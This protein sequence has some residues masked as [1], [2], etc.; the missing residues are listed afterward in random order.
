[1]FKKINKIIFLSIILFSSFGYSKENLTKI[2][3]IDEFSLFTQ[4][5]YLHPQP[6]LINQAIIFI[7]SSEISKGKNSQAP[8]VMIFSSLFSKYGDSK[9]SKWKRTINGIDEP[10]KSMLTF[11]INNTPF[12]ILN[13]TV[14]SPSKNDMNWACFF[15]TGETKYLDSIISELKYCDDRSNLR[16]F[17]AGTSA[18]WS[19]SSNARQDDRVR[20]YIESLKSKGDSKM[21]IL[22]SEILEKNPSYIQEETVNILKEQKRVGTWK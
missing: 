11:A 8:I 12:E 16:L 19:L 14:S 7:G 18:K 2:T 6:E 5:Y 15:I 17:L 9:K 21:R 13:K 10:A 20:E 4:K 22:A 3:N 1:M